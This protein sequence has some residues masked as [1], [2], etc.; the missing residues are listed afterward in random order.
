MMKTFNK[1]KKLGKMPSVIST[2][3]ESDALGRPKMLGWR[4]ALFEKGRELHMIVRDQSEVAE[5]L[6]KLAVYK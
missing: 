5:A 3:I 4:V 2:V 6:E 1:F